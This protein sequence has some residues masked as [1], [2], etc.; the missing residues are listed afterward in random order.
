[1]QEF[2]DSVAFALIGLA[3]GVGLFLFG[4]E[5]LVRT[6]QE[7]AGPKIRGAMTRMSRNQWKGLAAGTAASALLHSGPVAVILVGLVNAGILRFPSTLGMIAG[8]NVG[9]TFAIQVI[10][11]DIGRYSLALLGAGMLVR[12]FTK[13]RMIRHVSLGLVGFGLLFLGLEV[14]KTSMTPLKEYPIIGET[15]GA[16]RGDTLAGVTLG[17]VGG[18][19]LTLALQS[20]GAAISILF[21]LA[22]VGLLPD[23]R[24]IIPLLLGIQIGKCVPAV[25]AS[26]GGTVEGLRVTVAHVGFNVAALVLGIA[27]MGAAAW[28]IPVT[29]ASPIRQV[30]NYN[31]AIMIV[32]ALLLIPFSAPF[33]RLV[34]YLTRR[35]KRPRA[36]VSHLDPELIHTPEKAISAAVREIRRQG[37]YTRQMLTSTLDGMVSL[38]PRAFDEVDRIERAVDT[39]KHEIERYVGLIARRRLSPRQVLMLQHLARMANALER[40]GDH[41]ERLGELTE[42]KIRRRLWFSDED[43]ARLLDLSYRVRAMLEETLETIDPDVKNTVKLASDILSQRAQYKEASKSLRAEFHRRLPEEGGEGVTA[44]FYIHF[45]TIL[46]KVVSHLKEVARQERAWSWEV[47]DHKL[48]REEPVAPLAHPI[49]KNPRI[50]PDFDSA[51]RR[52]FPGRALPEESHGKRG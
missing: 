23:L 43:M 35:S 3:G 7:A 15:L 11:F 12:V 31:T 9:T 37:E 47:K 5:C 1:M 48:G 17:I 21:S 40:A 51:I 19:V 16:L 18:L 29:S 45:V 8:A 4:I 50:D 2:Q 36:S 10:A 28:L 46:D 20:S 39:I 30:A 42:E 6:F 27:T 22:A 25:L 34:T 33:S 24:S 32:T 44:L 49:P 52:V 13:G 38:D 41:I 26:I 14:M